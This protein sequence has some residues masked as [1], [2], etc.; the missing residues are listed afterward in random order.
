MENKEK[1]YECAYCGYTAPQKFTS[2][3]CPDCGQTFWKCHN[4]GYILTA[5]MPPEECPDCH[6]KCEFLNVTC[7]TPD[8]GGPGKI[9][10]R[11]G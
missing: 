9:D 5:S 6:E 1:K 7:Y 8:C 3:I 11:L 10:P 4:C 2:D